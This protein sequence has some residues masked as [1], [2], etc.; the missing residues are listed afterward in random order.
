M[1]GVN[2]L[3]CHDVFIY[4]AHSLTLPV[5]PLFGSIWLSLFKVIYL[6]GMLELSF[7]PLFVLDSCFTGVYNVRGE[8]ARYV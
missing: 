6:Y 7:L 5:S 4:F 8:M 1:H 3:G 2:I